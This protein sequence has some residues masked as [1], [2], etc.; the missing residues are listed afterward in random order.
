VIWTG[1]AQTAE[2][3]AETALQEDADAVGIVGDPGSVQEELRQRGLAD[4]A[5]LGPAS[6]TEWLAATG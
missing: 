4:V 5:V 6:T 2:Q 1:R 3:V